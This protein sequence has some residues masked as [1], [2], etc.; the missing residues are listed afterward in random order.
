MALVAFRNDRVFA[1]PRVAEAVPANA[2]I[3]TGSMCAA[4]RI[5]HYRVR[6]ETIRSMSQARGQID[7]LAGNIIKLTVPSLTVGRRPF[8]EVQNHIMDA[9]P[10]AVD[11]FSMIR[12]RNLKVH[13]AEDADAGNGLKFLLRNEIDPV[14]EEKLPVVMFD[15]KSAMIRGDFRL[16]QDQAG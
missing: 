6:I 14:L 15:E 8:T 7:C 11:E 4:N 9:P 1:G 5:G 10:H 16:D 2:A 3:V 13:A 12:W